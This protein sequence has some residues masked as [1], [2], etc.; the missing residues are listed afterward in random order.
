MNTK[1][2]KKFRNEFNK[3]ISIEL[4]CGQYENYILFKTPGFQCSLTRYVL[5][6]LD[7]CSSEASKSEI[8]A[9]LY[10]T[11][12]NDVFD[13]YYTFMKHKIRE[14]KEKYPYKSCKIKFV[15]CKK[16]KMI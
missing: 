6:A 12:S 5:D 8:A 7:K 15:K 13:T 1:L 14:Y 16:R 4:V 2:L 10:R 11:A 9:K 3:Q